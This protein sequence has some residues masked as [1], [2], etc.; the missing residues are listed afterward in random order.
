MDAFSEECARHLA[1]WLDRPLASL[2]RN[3]VATRHEEL[4]DTSGPYLA[5]RVLQQFRAVYNT[6]ARRFEDLPP[7]NPVI[8]VTFNRVRRRRQPIPWDEL[9][10]WRQRVDS[11]SNPVRRDLQ[12]F[13]LFTGL[14]SL[15]ARTVR[16][17]HLDLD[18]ATLHRP[19]PKG[20]EDRAFTVPLAGCVVHLLR[21]RIADN[22]LRYPG[23]PSWLFPTRDRTGRITH[24]QEPKEQRVVAGRKV[25][26]LPSPHRLRDTFAS[27][28]HE[29]RVHPLDLKVLMNHALPATDD[30][31]EGYIRPSIDHLRGCVEE[32]A[33]FLRSRMLS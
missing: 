13:L 31:T 16:V 17:E 19:R 23:A 15:D 26:W 30:V 12:L 29:A 20:G 6:A 24:V 25:P 2:R 22:A 4:T 21:A 14:R 18:A 8:A 9:P 5:N 27:A 3:E 33:A 32:V 28:A 10:A 11:L 7:T 1:P